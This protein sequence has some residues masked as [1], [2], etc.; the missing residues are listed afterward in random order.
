MLP[1]RGTAMSR[2]EIVSFIADNRHLAPFL[3]LP[4]L[5]HASNP[6]WIAPSK[7]VVRNQVLNGSGDRAHSI[8]ENLI[9]YDSSGRPSG[10]LSVMLNHSLNNDCDKIGL[11]GF[12]ECIN[13]YEIANA[14]LSHARNT[15]AQLG[16]RE[17]WG[18]MNL[19]TLHSYR[20]MTEGFDSPGFYTEPQNPAYYPTFFQNFGFE[21]LRTYNSAITTELEEIALRYKPYR[22]NL[23]NLGYTIRDFRTAAFDEEIELLFK[24]VI[25]IF[26]ANFGFT[27]LPLAEFRKLYEHYR[28]KLEP[29]HIRFVHDE[30][31]VPVAFLISIPDFTGNFPRT[32]LTKMLGVAKGVRGKGISEALYHDAIIY[33]LSQG[34]RQ[35]ISPL[36]INGN[37]SERYGGEETFRIFRRYTLYRYIIS[38]DFSS[39]G[40]PGAGQAQE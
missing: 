8:L 25:D 32:M 31:N 2:T 26:A 14:L 37:P 33:H 4:S 29:E 6:E 30:H 36:R 17:I 16:Y 20:F 39:L 21:S 19:S 10:R 38:R 23:S 28:E 18:P 7:E 3:D 5:L 13:S 22:E 11:V 24:L 9:A 12:F 1:T 40:T 34:C 27:K 35:L 15:L